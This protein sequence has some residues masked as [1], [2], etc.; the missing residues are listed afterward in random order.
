[1]A[2]ASLIGSPKFEAPPEGLNE[3]TLT[4]FDDDI[5][6][7]SMFEEIV[8]SSEAI[9]CVTAQVLRVAPSDATVLI[10]GESGTGKE[11]IARA[12]HKR[13]TRSRKPFVCMNCAATP[14]SLI[15][16][17]LFG[18]ER[19]AF[20]GAHQRRAGR[21]E[22]ANHGTLFLD[23][24]GDM[25]A[26]TQVSLLRVL[27][28][29]EFERVGG[30][31]SIPVDVR[32]IAATNRDLSTEVGSRGFRRDLFYRL[33]V[34]PIHVPP[35]R[36]RREDI[37]LLAKYFIDRYAANT[38]KRI[39]SVNKRTAQ[40]LKAYHWPGNI[41]ELQNV[42]QRAVILCEADEFSVEEGWLQSNSGSRYDARASHNV[43]EK[44]RIEAALEES[45][46]RI[47]GA[48][49]A[50]IRLGIPRTTLEAKIKRLTINKYKYQVVGGTL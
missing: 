7:T 21:F 37:L 12:I 17:D 22:V 9:C 28:E 34:F 32:V 40:L 20:T 5:L 4:F 31:R 36:E 33:N 47:S 6:S 50:A 29:R 43:E 39:R 26:E 49:G 8:G 19:G 1:M 41:R 23:E 14:P 16:A 11:L 15:A 46:G 24:I 25:P 13:S 45:R 27:Q 10:T 44:A 30:N 35:L 2:A 18:H 38:H 42:I 48:R 3:E